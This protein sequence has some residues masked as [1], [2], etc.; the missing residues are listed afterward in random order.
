M[1]NI[2]IV[3][4]EKGRLDQAVDYYQKALELKKK[5]G[6]TYGYA[7]TSKNLGW[8]SLTKKDYKQA[9]F[10]LHQSLEIAKKIKA[11]DLIKDNYDLLSQYYSAIN[12]FEITNKGDYDVGTQ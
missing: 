12:D 10:Y 8:I 7:N 1:N 4:E 11:R 5:V 2:A 3:Y 9:D 6:D